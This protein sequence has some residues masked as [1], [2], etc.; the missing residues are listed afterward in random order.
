MDPITTVITAIT[1]ALAAGAADG[2]KGVATKAVADGHAALKAAIARVFGGASD[3]SRAVQEV[4]ASPGE[5]WRYGQ[6]EARLKSASPD[7]VAEISKAAES[8]LATVERQPGGPQVVQQ[9][10]GKFIAQASGGTA[11]V[12]VS[13][14][15]TRE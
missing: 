7:G 2:A 6:L 12:N 4:E 15:R 3:V 5:D 8:L 11:S 10:K 14:V 13:G 1:A 9:A